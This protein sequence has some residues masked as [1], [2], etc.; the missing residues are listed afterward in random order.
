MPVVKNPFKIVMAGLI[1][2]DSRSREN[3]VRTNGLSLGDRRRRRPPPFGQRPPRIDE[4]HD[5]RRQEERSGDYVEIIE[6]DFADIKVWLVENRDS[7]PRYVLITIFIATASYQTVSGLLF[8]KSIL[9]SALTF[10]HHDYHFIL[11]CSD[12]LFVVWGRWS[13]VPN[14]LISL[15][16][17]ISISPSLSFCR[18]HHTLTLS[19]VIWT[20]KTSVDAIW[21]T[22]T[23]VYGSFLNPLSQFLIGSND[24][25]SDWDYLISN[26]TSDY[27]W[28]P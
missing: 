19:C 5:P 15:M 11:W 3:L 22:D 18:T 13:G 4:H 6:S 26:V 23:T 25:M 24:I 28:S 27:V 2:Y 9:S 12:W 21:L 7:I 17:A 14:P 8:T 16:S 1:R 20:Q 10:S